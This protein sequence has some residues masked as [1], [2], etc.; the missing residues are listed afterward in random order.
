VATFSQTF[1]PSLRQTYAQSQINGDSAGGGAPPV[2]ADYVV[3]TDAEWTAAIAAVSDGEII[4]VSVSNFTTRSV[5]NRIIATG[6]TIRGANTSAELPFG[7][8]FSGTVS[9]INFEGPLIISRDIAATSGWWSPKAVSTEGVVIYSSTPVISDIVFDGVTFDGGLDPLLDGGLNTSNTSLNLSEW[10]G[11]AVRN[12]TVRRI[13]TAIYLD[14]CQNVT[15][16]NN[17]ITA[18]IADCFVLSNGNQDCANNIIRN[19]HMSGRA[20][21]VRYHT[22]WLQFQPTN[23]LTTSIR[24]I[25]FYGNTMTFGDGPLMAQPDPISA[26]SNPVKTTK[27]PLELI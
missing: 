11:G 10:T 7:L 12:C 1:R 3:T 19:N 9:K 14:G 22:D 4:E 5:I 6:I 21:G 20:S 17:T 2:P 24:D 18:P 8:T 27:K 25:E 26:L 13:W 15:I 16:E 23:T